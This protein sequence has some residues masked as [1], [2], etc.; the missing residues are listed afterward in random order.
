MKLLIMT[1]V[2][3]LAACSKPPPP[4]PPKPPAPVVMVAV[5][6]PSAAAPANPAI[7]AQQQATLAVAASRTDGFVVVPADK[8]VMGAPGSELEDGAFND[9]PQH[10]VTLTRAFEIQAT[11]VTQHQYQDALGKL[12]PQQSTGCPECPVVGVS[13]FEAASYCNHLSAARK[14][15]KCYVISGANSATSQGSA[16]RGYR[17]PSEAEWEYAARA[18]TATARYGEL[19][20]IAWIDVN[21]AIGDALAL[22]PVGQKQANA[23]GLYDM[24][25]NASE[26]TSDWQGDLPSTPTTDPEGAAHGENRVFRGGNCKM[27]AAEARAGFRN[28]YGPGNQVEFIGFRC[29]R[30]L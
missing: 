9:A 8:F 19:D 22:H 1:S 7:L 24:L 14:L 21:S 27:P 15:P 25:G 4:A 13:W 18:G 3:A 12:E 26:W 17:L 6:V 16:C 5:P 29:V 23:W 30:T 11:E 2:L 28:A 10:E 20:A